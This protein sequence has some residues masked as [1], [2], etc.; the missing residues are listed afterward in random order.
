MV[1]PFQF[2]YL[3]AALALVLLVMS[4][5]A[6]SQCSAVHE[7]SLNRT[8][9]PSTFENT[10]ENLLFHTN[11][12]DFIRIRDSHS[13]GH[14][15]HFP[16]DLYD[17]S[18]NGCSYAPSKKLEPCCHRHD[19]GYRN[20]QKAQGCTNDDRKK[21]DKQF[22]RD[23]VGVCEKKGWFGSLVFCRAKAVVYYTGVRLGGKTSFC[24]K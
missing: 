3:A 2:V 11:L 16:Y 6:S 18:S 12:S 7:P 24:T 8:S 5:V 21:V 22:C 14:C 17:W 1:L 19:F 4:A 13:K 9:Y 10:R 15:K 23:M 20:Y